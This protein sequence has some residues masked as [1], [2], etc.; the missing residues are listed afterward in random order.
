MFD[1]SLRT[2]IAPG[3][4]CVIAVAGEIDLFTAP[5]LKQAASVAIDD[6]ARSIVVD[7]T[8]TRF[9]DSTGLG[10][11]IGIAKRLRPAG[12]D[13]AIVNTEPST[14]ATFAITGIDDLVTVV[15]TREQA[16]DALGSVVP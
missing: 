8:E 13:I 5:D 15:E 16:L 14:A 11:L 9:L 6:G 2:E 7:L 4:V 3:D 12:G 10:V 1:F